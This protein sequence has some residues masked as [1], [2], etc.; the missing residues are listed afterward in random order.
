M[1]EMVTKF[2]PAI[3]CQLT[4]GVLG[5]TINVFLPK[6]IQMTAE[7]VDNYN[8]EDVPSISLIFRG[9]INGRFII[10]FE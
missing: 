9:K 5:G 3:A 10:D 1:K 7:E 2:G 6:Y 8:K 4:D